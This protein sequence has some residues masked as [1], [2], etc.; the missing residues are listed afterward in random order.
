MRTA[1]GILGPILALGVL[2]GGVLAGGGCKGEQRCD[3]HSECLTTELCSDDSLCVH[4]PCFNRVEGDFVECDGEDAVSCDASQMPVVVACGQYGCTDGALGCAACVPGSGESCNA[5]DVITC[6]ANGLIESS[7]FC[8]TGCVEL[9]GGE[10]ECESCVP[11]TVAC[12]DSFL[13]SCDAAG[14]STG[15]ECG[16]GCNS[17]L[18]PPVCNDC[19]PDEQA[20]DG[21]E[22]MICGA[23]GME[24]SREAC[25]YGCAQGRQMCN[26]CYPDDLACVGDDLVTCGPL[27]L[28]VEI[29]E[30]ENGCDVENDRCYDCV[31]DTT[32][33][34]GDDLVDC[35]SGG[36]VASQITCDHGCDST[37]KACNDCTP[38]TVECVGGDLVTCGGDGLVAETTACTLGCNATALRCNIFQPTGLDWTD[39]TAGNDP[40]VVLDGQTALI[41]TEN[42]IVWVNGSPVSGYG[43]RTA[44]WGGFTTGWVISFSYVDIRGNVQITGS[45]SLALVART[46]ITVANNARVDASGHLDVPGP[47]GA[48]PGD[49]HLA[50][51]GNTICDGGGFP[52][53]GGGGHAGLGG[54]GSAVTGYTTGQGGSV[55]NDWQLN[56]L[57][58]GGA[59]GSCNIFGVGG[60]AGGNLL[61]VAGESIHI[62]SGSVV[63]ASGGGGQ[64]ASAGGGAGGLISVEAP[65]VTVEGT[66]RAAGGGGGCWGGQGADGWYSSSGCLDSSANGGDGGPRGTNTSDLSGE[67]GGVPQS[68][69]GA[70]GGGAA[71]IIIVNVGPSQGAPSL[72]GSYPLIPDAT[73]MAAHVGNIT[74]E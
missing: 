24:A 18:D 26:E 22:L 33:C 12:Y 49:A 6:D 28:P 58:G 20:C 37:R 29:D 45:Q 71:G 48:A 67:A 57:L 4:N 30:C 23:D 2:V 65:T 46:T 9:A 32:T 44:T 17:N 15:Q 66:L 59:G 70:G 38:S 47:G 13:V 8:V 3:D 74:P 56:P 63:H 73:S 50:N 7:A 43:S 60:A 53:G 39:V 5:N 55:V 14:V 34:S 69:Y 51:G 10:A 25:P 19:A 35:G 16:F 40:L 52:G 68:I 61:L 1:F 54:N 36:E 11:E 27:G 42:E 72:S 21:E 31:P 62:V 64:D 41:D